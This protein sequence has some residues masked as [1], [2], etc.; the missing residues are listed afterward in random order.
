M[1]TEC[2]SSG[3]KVCGDVKNLYNS[4]FADAEP[5]TFES[6]LQ[7]A[8]DETVSFKAFYNDTGEFIGFIYYEEYMDSIF[9]LYMAIN[10][11][12]QHQGFAKRIC[13]D[14]FS[15]KL[16]QKTLVNDV[17]MPKDSADETDFALRRIRM[18][19]SPTFSMKQTKYSISTGSC[20][21][22]IMSSTGEADIEKYVAFLY[23]YFKKDAQGNPIPRITISEEKEKI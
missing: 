22:L 16:L 21:Y 15:E 18:F 4:L 14:E 1:K 13:Y 6:L 23:K 10:P 20:K 19:E 11:A 17:E 9:I 3:T 12:F 2:V 7:H 5:I 8:E